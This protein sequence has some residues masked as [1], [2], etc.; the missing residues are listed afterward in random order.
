MKLTLIGLAMAFVSGCS[1]ITAA[2]LEAKEYR[3]TEFRNQFLE[4]R[5]RCAASG[6]RLTV[7]AAGGALDRH[8]IPRSRVRYYCT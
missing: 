6:R 8:G 2:Q 7:F 4:D 3:R 1:T 5:A